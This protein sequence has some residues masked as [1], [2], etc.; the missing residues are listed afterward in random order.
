[1]TM[2]RTTLVSNG[3]CTKRARVHDTPVGHQARSEIPVYG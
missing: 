1:M 2:D 3:T